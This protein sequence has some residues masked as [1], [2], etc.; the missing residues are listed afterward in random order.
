MARLD[1]E[2]NE[3]TCERSGMGM[4]ENGVKCDVVMVEKKHAQIV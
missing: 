1:C 3:G 4:S 2:N